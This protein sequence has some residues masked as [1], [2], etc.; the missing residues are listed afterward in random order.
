MIALLKQYKLIA[1][2][3]ALALAFGAG[4]VVRGWWATATISELNAEHAAYREAISR[5]HAQKLVVLAG[6]QKAIQQRLSA[7]DQQRYGELRHAQQEIDRLS[8][9][10]A[11]GSRRL[12]VRTS[13]PAAAGSVSAAT[14]AGRLDDGSQRA[15]IHEEDARRIVAITGGADACAVKLTALQEWAREVTKGN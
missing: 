15:D 11:D 12:S 5:E 13:C 2:G 7:L 9:A 10:V 1:A 3:A 6:E 14:G 8:A 4:M